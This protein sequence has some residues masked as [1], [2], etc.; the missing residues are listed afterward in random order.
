MLNLKSQKFGGVF[1]V[2]TIE[3]KIAEKEEL[4]G[5]A[6]FWDNPSKA[7]KVMTEI[8]NLKNRI[9]PWKAL[10]QQVE[11]IQTLY[12]LAEETGDDSLEAEISSEFNKIK[13]EFERLSILNL[14]SDE[15]DRNGC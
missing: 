15:V 5:Q 12:D 14:L 9:E 1:D 4:S 7:E 6:G 2:P 8:K 13:A 11:D 3:A 10:I